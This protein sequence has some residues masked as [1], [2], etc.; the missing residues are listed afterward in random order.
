[1]LFYILILSVTIIYG[2][3]PKII[4]KN[5]IPHYEIPDWVYEEV[6]EHNKIKKLN[7]NDTYIDNQEIKLN[8]IVSYLISDYQNY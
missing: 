4:R 1:M 2:F 6:F 5:T 3:N 8:S 7:S